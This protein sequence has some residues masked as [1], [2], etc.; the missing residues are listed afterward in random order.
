M[1]V[2]AREDGAV[3]PGTGVT[4]D[5]EPACGCWELNSGPLEEQQELLTATS[6][7]PRSLPSFLG[8]M[9]PEDPQELVSSFGKGLDS[10]C[11]ALW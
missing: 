6:L 5:C 11:W 4:D 8:G 7:A 1:P 10:S 3:C 2:K 9:R